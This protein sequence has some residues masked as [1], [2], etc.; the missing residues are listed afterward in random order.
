[1]RRSLT[2][3]EKIAYR[4]LAHDGVSAIWKLQIAAAE[5]HATGYPESA[6][7]IVEIAEAAEQPW[8]RPALNCSFA[9]MIGAL[10]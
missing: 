3:T 8:L 4:T 7:V 6:R 1:M 2:S 9:D 10:R 5:A